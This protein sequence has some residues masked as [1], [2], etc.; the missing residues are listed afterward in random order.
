MK[1]RKPVASVSLDLDNKWAYLKGAGNPDWE[2]YPS[3]FNTVVPRMLDFLEQRN[4]KITFFVVGRDAELREN[5]DTL[6][7]IGDAGHEIA[8]HTQ[9]HVQGFRLLSVA[10]KEAELAAM[11]EACEQVVGHRPVGFRSPGW[12]VGDDALPILKRRGYIY[13]S[14]VFRDRPTC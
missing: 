12:N 4:L 14:S 8:N 10:E 13:D 1:N 9:T 5:S 7:S 3:Y 6:W 11:E 2:S